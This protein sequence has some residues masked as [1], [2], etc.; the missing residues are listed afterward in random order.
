MM[1]KLLVLLAAG[2]LAA[3]I[4]AC[5][6]NGASGGE[7]RAAEERSSSYVVLITGTAGLGDQGVNDQLW[8]GIG[9]AGGELGIRGNYLESKTEAEYGEKIRMALEGE[10]DLI[11]CADPAMGSAAAAAAEE[12]PDS[13]FV[14]LDTIIEK[15]N[16]ACLTCA[17]EQGAFLAGLAAGMTT[18]TG[19]V[20]FLGGGETEESR[21]LLWGWEA[22]VR[23]SGSGA[24]TCCAFVEESAGTAAEKAKELIGQGADVI[25]QAS[26]SS[27]A[28]VIRAAA[29]AG[30]MAVGTG[31]DLSSLA[32]E[33]VLCTVTRRRDR[34][35]SRLLESLTSDGFS[36]GIIRGSLEDGCVE[37]SDGA[38]N[39]PPEV[40]EA[41]DKWSAA[42]AD[43]AVNIPGDRDELERFEPQL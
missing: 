43:G 18:E 1:K 29:E 2:I 22:G 6:A 10:A 42:I 4:S 26:G 41:A 40:R 33:H 25:F 17:R 3:G 36:G 34:E 35:I 21:S 13:R 7:G 24:E 20:A 37:L 28:E 8:E 5:G 39:L 16:V 11:I 14:I 9:N 19:K 23:A 32:P 15:D 31:E 27:G 30:V 12:N 38:G